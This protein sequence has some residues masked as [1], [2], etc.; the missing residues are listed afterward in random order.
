MPSLLSSVAIVVLGLG[1]FPSFSA[2]S[3]SSDLATKT[4]V[5]LSAPSFAV[6]GAS[7]DETKFGTIVRRLLCLRYCL[8]YLGLQVFKTMLEQGLN[9]VPINPF[10]SESQGIT[11]LDTLASLPDPA[12]TSISIVTQPAVT[13]QILQQASALG[14]LA[15][16]LQ[17]GAQ[18]EAVLEFINSTT[19]GTTYIYSSAISTDTLGPCLFDNPAMPDLISTLGVLG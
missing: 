1:F 19:D 14:I 8:A 5:F 6:V 11:C 9:A 7:D 10:V 12:H 17:P 15:A 4:T 16:W 2:A 18:D 3:N 13:L